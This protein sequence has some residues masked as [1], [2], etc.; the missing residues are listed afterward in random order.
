[1]RESRA[2]I[3]NRNKCETGGSEESSTL[4]GITLARVDVLSES[5]ENVPALFLTGGG[6][7]PLLVS[8]PRDG[9]PSTMISISVGMHC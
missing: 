1:M 3:C 5:Q 8:N 6:S 4:F 7:E 2:S 9:E